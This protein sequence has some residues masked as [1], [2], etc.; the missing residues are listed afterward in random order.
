[1]KGEDGGVTMECGAVSQKLNPLAF[2]LPPPS[3]HVQ[4]SLH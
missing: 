2:L 1:M 4:L 3:D